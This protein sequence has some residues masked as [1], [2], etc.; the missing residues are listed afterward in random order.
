MR[1]LGV[2]YYGCAQTDANTAQRAHSAEFAAVLAALEIK[3]TKKSQKIQA[4]KL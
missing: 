3:S 2:F 1:S 4:N